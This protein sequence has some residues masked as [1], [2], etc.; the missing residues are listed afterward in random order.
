VELVQKCAL[1]GCPALIAVSA[2]TAHAVRLAE[3]AGITLVA[4]VR[5][6][7]GTVMSHPGR[8]TG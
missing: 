2:P 1:A 4:Q 7:G 6:G 5:D 8:I 3:A